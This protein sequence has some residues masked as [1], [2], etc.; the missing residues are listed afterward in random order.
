MD[1]GWICH[2]SCD[3]NVFL[4]LY[5]DTDWP[6]PLFTMIVLG[7]MNMQPFFILLMLTKLSKH[8]DVIKWKH[9]PRYWPFVRGIRGSS[10][11]SPHKGQWRRVLMFS[12]I[13]V[14]INGRVNNREVGDLRRYCAHYDVIVMENF[15]TSS[16]L[17]RHIIHFRF[18]R[19]WLPVDAWYQDISGHDIDQVSPDQGHTY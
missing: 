17:S 1:E 16:W 12:L 10:V 14:W 4:L 8:D 7:N 3:M 2:R 19:C 13:C 5:L 6:S 15:N 11:N 9:F 18:D